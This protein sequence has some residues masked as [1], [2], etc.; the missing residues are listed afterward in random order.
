VANS[1]P[2]EGLGKVRNYKWQIAGQKRG[3][4]KLEIANGK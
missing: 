3:W 1:K 4:E 2:E